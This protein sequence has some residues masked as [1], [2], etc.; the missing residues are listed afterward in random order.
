MVTAYNSEGQTS[1]PWQQV[2][3]KEGPPEGVPA[4]LVKVCIGGGEHTIAQWLVCKTSD[5]LESFVN[6]SSGLVRS[7]LFLLLRLLLSLPVSF[8]S[9]VTP[10]NL[11]L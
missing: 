2:R 6:C 10:N 7:S 8:C 9:A 5:C 11:I 1:S 3:T 4:P